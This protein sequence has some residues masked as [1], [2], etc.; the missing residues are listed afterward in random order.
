MSLLQ[1]VGMSR[2]L[3]APHDLKVAISPQMQLAAVQ[4]M[5]AQLAP[6]APDLVSP[7]GAR[8]EL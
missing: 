5:S 1:I 8:F 7:A 2:L 4:Y 3:A 6:F